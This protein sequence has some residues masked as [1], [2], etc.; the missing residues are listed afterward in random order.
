MLYETFT[1]ID[2]GET[3]TRAQAEELLSIEN[4]T[5]DYYTL[6]CKANA[7]ARNQFGDK[8]KG[9]CANWV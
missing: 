2:A 8:G 9:V 3:L 7:Y 1:F 4:H 6:L 5:Q